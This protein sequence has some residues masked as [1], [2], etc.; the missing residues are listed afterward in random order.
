LFEIR[1]PLAGEFNQSLSIEIRPLSSD[2]FTL[3]S[4]YLFEYKKTTK[5]Y[6]LS[7]KSYSFHNQKYMRKFA[8]FISDEGKVQKLSALLSWS[9]NTLLLDKTKTLVQLFV[10]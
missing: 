5:F 6:N 4:Q 9:H 8:E 1:P 2:E 10:S 7:H 3:I